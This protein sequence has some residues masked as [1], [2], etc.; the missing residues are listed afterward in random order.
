MEEEE[1]GAKGAG[2]ELCWTL[3]VAGLVQGGL[4]SSIA[5]ASPGLEHWWGF[6]L[7]GFGWRGPRAVAAVVHGLWGS[8]IAMAL[9]GLE[10]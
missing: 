6:C 3:A 8:F 1:E 2:L 10:H 9:L 4:G 5:G 7:L